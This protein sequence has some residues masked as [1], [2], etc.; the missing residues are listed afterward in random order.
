MHTWLLT[1]GLTLGVA[2]D[3]NITGEEE[4]TV[5]PLTSGILYVS[6]SWA[7]DENGKNIAPPIKMDQHATSTRYNC[8]IILD[9]LQNVWFLF[10]LFLGLLALSDAAISV[11]FLSLGNCHVRSTT[12]NRFLRIGLCLFFCLHHMTFSPP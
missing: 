8:I 7:V 3:M 4:A 2:V 9:G 10:V 1:L 6:T 5:I 12:T 11:E